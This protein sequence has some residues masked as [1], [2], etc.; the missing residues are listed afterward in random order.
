MMIELPYPEYKD[1]IIRGTRK[2]HYKRTC[3]GVWQYAYCIT[4]TRGRIQAAII[5]GPAPYPTV[6]RA[7]CRRSED[8]PKHIWIQ[9]MWG[10]GISRSQLDDLI[11]FSHKN[12][13]DRGYWWLH[14]MTNPHAYV[15]DA[16]LR[17]RSNGYTGATYHRNQYLYLGWAGR[18]ALTGFLI[19]GHPHHIRQGKITLTLS[20]VYDYFPNAKSIRPLHG[21]QK[22]RWV[23][24]CASTP[25]EYQQRLLLMK[26]HPQLYEPLRQPRLLMEL[27][28]W[29]SGYPQ[30]QTP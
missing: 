27:T 14:T 2:H 3:T 10:A 24:L 26:Y 19:D 8:I 16:P 22:Q 21:K 13:I 7:F 11:A 18:K 29:F 9:R 23:Y 12:L 20:N 6:S 28:S 30:L 5:Y 17:L 4:N 1:D 25:Q 15:I